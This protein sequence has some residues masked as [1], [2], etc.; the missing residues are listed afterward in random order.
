MNQKWLRHVST[1]KNEKQQE[2]IYFEA[3]E[4]IAI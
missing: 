2:A 4:N 1:I 3:Y